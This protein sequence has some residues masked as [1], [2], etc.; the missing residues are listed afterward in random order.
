MSKPTT[1]PNDQKAHE[2]RRW[3]SVPEAAHYLGVSEPTI[4]RWMKDSQ[5]SFYKIGGATR[6]TQ[7]GLDAVI[8]KT[9]GSKE[10]EAA[11]GRCAA[12]GHSVLVEGRLRGA[13][14][15]YFQPVETKFWTFE[16]SL[17]P[18]RA[19]VCTAC[20]HIQLHAETAKL[21]RLLPGEK[22]AP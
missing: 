17:V 13:G 9:T 11:A 19:R 10:A 5:L 1:T 7:E 12:C 2:E 6:F 18:T 16:E 3:Y 20:G 21:H 4:F 8:E 14:R 15:L 22:E